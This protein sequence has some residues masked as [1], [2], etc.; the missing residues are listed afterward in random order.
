MVLLLFGMLYDPVQNQYFW[1]LTLPLG[2]D[3]HI[4]ESRQEEIR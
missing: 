2:N 4:R 1:E 3:K